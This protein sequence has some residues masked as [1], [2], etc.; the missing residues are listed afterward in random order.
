[1]IR[2]I[3][4]ATA[5]FAIG[6]AI[7]FRVGSRFASEVLVEYLARNLNPNTFRL[8]A[9]ELPTKRRKP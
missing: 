5:T 2:L 1:M 9:D 8:L 6:L 7:G 3:L 4:V